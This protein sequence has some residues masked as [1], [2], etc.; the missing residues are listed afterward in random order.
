M[1]SRFDLESA[2][3]VAVNDAHMQYEQGTAL[4]VDVRSAEDFDKCH[5]PGAVSIPLPE[6]VARS[7]ELPQGR[8]IIT[9]C[10]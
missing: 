4:F 6:I 9:Y 2:P 8:T 5:I 3:R 1:Q 10:T 7:G